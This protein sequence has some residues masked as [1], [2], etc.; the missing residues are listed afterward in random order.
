MRTAVAETILLALNASWRTEM[1]WS[2]QEIVILTGLPINAVSGRV[3]ELKNEAS[4]YLVEAPKRRC[5]VTGRLVTPV[6]LRYPRVQR[7]LF[8]A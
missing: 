6:A 7:E 5:S 2:L 3:N 4:R 1:N 8:A